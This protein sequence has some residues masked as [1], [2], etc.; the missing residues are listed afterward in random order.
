MSLD[1][2]SAEEGSEWS[3][4]RRRSRPTDDV[5]MDAAGAEVRPFPQ[6][7]NQIAYYHP[8]GCAEEGPDCPLEKIKAIC[9][10]NDGEEFPTD[11]LNVNEIKPPFLKGLYSDE[12]IDED[13][14]T[15]RN[16]G[17]A[18]KSDSNDRRDR[19]GRG[20]CYTD[21][22]GEDDFRREIVDKGKRNPS[23]GAEIVFV[24]RAL[25]ELQRIRPLFTRAMEAATHD[26]EILDIVEDNFFIRAPF[27][28]V[29]DVNGNFDRVENTDLKNAQDLAKVCGAKP[30]DNLTLEERNAF[31]EYKANAFDD[32]FD[33]TVQKIF[34]LLKLYFISRKTVFA[35]GCDA[36]TENASA[37]LIGEAIIQN[38]VNKLKLLVAPEQ[39]VDVNAGLKID[40]GPF[41]VGEIPIMMAI[42]HD[43]D[44]P[45]PEY[46][47]ELLKN[48]T[49][50]VNK[51]SP[52]FDEPLVVFFGGIPF[53]VETDWKKWSPMLEMLLADKRTNVNTTGGEYRNTALH[54]A[55]D[56]LNFA[57]TT[58]QALDFRRE[59][60]LR[61]LLN[62]GANPS[63]KNASGKTSIDLVFSLD[64]L[65]VVDLLTAAVT[66]N[67]LF[68]TPLDRVNAEDARA[69]LRSGTVRAW[70]GVDRIPKTLRFNI[71]GS[72]LFVGD[73]KGLV[74]LDSD[75]GLVSKDDVH[76]NTLSIELRASSNEYS[77]DHR[78]FAFIAEPAVL[79][80]V[81]WETKTVVF[82]E[83]NVS[84]FTFHPQNPTV[85]ALVVGDYF[86]RNTLRVDVQLRSTHSGDLLENFPDAAGPLAFS[87]DGTRLAMVSRKNESPVVIENVIRVSAEAFLENEKTRQTIDVDQPTNEHVKMLKHA[88][89]LVIRS[90]SENDTLWK[91]GRFVPHVESL[92]FTFDTNGENNPRFRTLPD[93]LRKWSGL[94]HIEFRPTSHFQ[95]FPDVLIKMPSL[96][97]VHF[98]QN[99][100]PLKVPEALRDKTHK[101]LFR[102]NDGNFSEPTKFE[103]LWGFDGE[104]ECEGAQ[105]LT[106]EE[107]ITRREGPDAP[108]LTHTGTQLLAFLFAEKRMYETYDQ[109]EEEKE[110]G[111]N[112]TNYFNEEFLDN[113][114]GIGMTAFE[115]ARDRIIN[116][117]CIQYDDDWIID[118]KPDF[119]TLGDIDGEDGVLS[120]IG[121]E[122][123]EDWFA[124]DNFERDMRNCA[125]HI[126]DYQ[127][128]SNEKTKGLTKWRDVFLHLNE[129]RN[130]EWMRKLRHGS[131]TLWD[132]PQFLNHVEHLLDDK[133][134]IRLEALL[135]LNKLRM[136]FVLLTHFASGIWN[137]TIRPPVFAPP[138]DAT[139]LIKRSDYE[140]NKTIHELFVET[141]EDDF[142]RFKDERGV[143]SLERMLHCDVEKTFGFDVLLWLDNLD[144]L[145][146]QELKRQP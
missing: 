38:D 27:D 116:V 46:L 127:Y 141:W 128:A 138:L 73:E 109:Y 76:P 134:M 18:Q 85:M 21:G 45:R 71:T 129:Q 34:F 42:W 88:R 119:R 98:F 24:S 104:S 105:Q 4:S 32:L 126:R 99:E 30:N 17:K 103:L 82:K 111:N 110:G 74:K 140:E 92:M 33:D 120:R 96:R 2:I 113:F 75:T 69:K 9:H 101:R 83:K 35:H 60:V 57:C 107:I 55:C 1:V 80:V 52:N 131:E 121:V 40:L 68:I 63:K 137:F 20:L 49:I 56:R 10:H 81:E 47:R 130:Q 64:T 43:I 125:E 123:F 89:N 8:T 44:N 79:H 15:Y 19:R 37:E 115:L 29:Q 136:T 90:V 145:K 97:M 36:I 62:A 91:L 14:N 132:D 112:F 22:V 139:R 11:E 26:R 72:D 16:A 70:L 67:G 51:T 143:L 124:S 95:A 86:E 59:M 84:T 50:D 54:N 28:Y 117:N 114:P 58:S 135:T 106:D 23:N 53:G 41:K 93:D 6:N 7:F 61:M 144:N 78:Y 39:G 100:S 13:G 5:P 65:P 87:P 122:K 31:E 48:P 12:H 3:G 146:K 108:S 118:S 66:R 94:R 102:F 142:P 25:T 77:A 133:D